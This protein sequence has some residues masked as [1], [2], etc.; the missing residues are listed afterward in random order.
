M[1]DTLLI[2]A[3]TLKD[4]SGLHNNVDEDLLL[5]EIKFS[6]DSFIMP[7][8]G[9]RMYEKIQIDIENNTLAGVYETLVDKYITDALVYHTLSQLPMGIS[10]QFY[11]KG[12]VRKSSDNTDVPDMQQ[13]IDIANRYQSRA[14]FYKDKLIN[15]L[16]ANPEDYPEYT[17]WSLTIE[18][19]APE[20]HAYSVDIFLD[21]DC[22]CL[23]GTTFEERYQGKF[24]RCK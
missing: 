24:G 6:Q 2:S 11:N 3:T 1:R 16:K 14:E 4:R 9:S 20:N 7:A 21:D 22:G 15:H 10:Y 13:L 8:I 17:A 12:L 23:G 19:I 18:D 5:P